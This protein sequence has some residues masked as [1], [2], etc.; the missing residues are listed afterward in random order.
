MIC[1]ALQVDAFTD[2][3][4]KGNSAAVC[5]LEDGAGAEGEHLDERWMQAV[6][7][8]FN[9]PIT[10]FLVRFGSS[11]AGAD[12]AGVGVTAVTPQFRIRWFT[13]V[14]EVIVSVTNIPLF[15]SYKN[16]LALVC[17]MTDE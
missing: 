1:L 15:L 3:P 2:E 10:A 11:G 17:L 7:A 5:I 8:E 16:L 12:A 4:F 14:R 6:A 13:P 9:T